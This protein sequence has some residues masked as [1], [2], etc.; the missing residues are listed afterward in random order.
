LVAHNDSTTPPCCSSGLRV[1]QSGYAVNRW[2][3]TER[4]C[5]WG[6]VWFPVAVAAE[7][8]TYPLPFVCQLPHP[9][10]ASRVLPV[11]GACAG[12]KRVFEHL[13]TRHANT[14]KPVA[15]AVSAVTYNRVRFG[16]Q[17]A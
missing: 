9:V 17:P 2:Q 14:R 11:V 3:L 10:L 8:Y 12:G 7:V 4:I 6:W 1:F 16:L 15:V 5:A 13:Y